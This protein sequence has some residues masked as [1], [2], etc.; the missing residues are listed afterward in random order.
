MI[1]SHFWHCDLFLGSLRFLLLYS[2]P[3]I[4]FKHC[5]QYLLCS[6]AFCNEGTLFTTT[7]GFS[8]TISD[9]FKSVVLESPILGRRIIC[10]TT[11]DFANSN[12]LSKRILFSW[13]LLCF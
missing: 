6:P 9:I 2:S 7:L 11:S 13:I 3:E 5:R 4:S 8:S 10:G 1:H 12:P